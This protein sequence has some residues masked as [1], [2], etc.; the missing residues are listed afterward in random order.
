MDDSSVLGSIPIVDFG[1][2]SLEKESPDPE[3]LQKLVD[4]VHRALTTIGFLY[5]K[6]TGCPANVVIKNVFEKSKVFFDLDKKEKSKYRRGDI[7]A[8]SNFGYIELEQEGLNPERRKDLKEAFNYEPA[9]TE[10]IPNELA[11]KPKLNDMMEAL[12][13]FFEYGKS[14]HDRLLEIIAKGLNFEDTQ[15]F[16]KRHKSIGEENNVT[17]VR[18][19]YYPPIRN[20]DVKKNQIRCGEHVD[21]GCVALLIQNNEGLEVR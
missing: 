11:G 12:R 10:K 1:A 8:D 19:L 6:N 4:E 18:S 9:E 14:I 2:Y 20:K 3:R 17:M 16:V 21:Y 13:T 7:I 15:Y 5:L